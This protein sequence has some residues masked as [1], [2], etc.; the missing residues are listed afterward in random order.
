MRA[1]ILRGIELV[2][3]S[4]ERAALAPQ[5]PRPKPQAIGSE[6]P[7]SLKLGDEDV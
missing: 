1:I 5:E 6:S 2:L 7:G 4:E 3:A